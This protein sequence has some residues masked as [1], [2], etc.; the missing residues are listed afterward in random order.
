[1]VKQQ[2]FKSRDDHELINPD[3]HIS[4]YFKG[5]RRSITVSN[6]KLSVIFH[7]STFC[8]L[9]S[10]TWMTTIPSPRLLVEI[11]AEKQHTDTQLFWLFCSKKRPQR[12][13]CFKHSF[14][15]RLGQTEPQKQPHLDLHCYLSKWHSLF[16]A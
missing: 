16:S 5:N 2:E 13:H 4:E 12:E 6:H 14:L 9:S 1:M 3:N 8:L 7:L 11:P 10:G 15:Q